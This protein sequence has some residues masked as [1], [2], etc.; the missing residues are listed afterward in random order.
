MKWPNLIINPTDFYTFLY[1]DYSKCTYYKVKCE[2][3]INILNT[4]DT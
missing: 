3:N 1:F 4:H 2:I